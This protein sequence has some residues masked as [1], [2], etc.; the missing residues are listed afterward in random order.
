MEQE[1][2][3]HVNRKGAEDLVAETKRTI[4]RTS[5]QQD[6]LAVSLW[7][8]EGVRHVLV[9]K[10][11]GGRVSLLDGEKKAEYHFDSLQDLAAHVSAVPPNN[12]V[13]E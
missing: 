7:S 2:V 1:W 6:C 11:N 8:H 13:V 4:I 9:Q 12:N 5:S 3:H 10:D